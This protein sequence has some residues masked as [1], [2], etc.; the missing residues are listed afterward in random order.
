[1]Y[2]WSAAS[3]GEVRCQTSSV[4]AI[5]EASGLNSCFVNASLSVVSTSA[6]LELSQALL[7]PDN[8]LHD[9]LSWTGTCDS[10][11]HCV[12]LPSR[13]ILDLPYSMPTKSVLRRRAFTTRNQL[14]PTSAIAHNPHSFKQRLTHHADIIPIQQ[15]LR[16]LCLPAREITVLKSQHASL[17]LCLTKPPVR[18]LEVLGV[19]WG[20]GR[21]GKNIQFSNVLKHH[22]DVIIE[23][24][25]RP[26]EF[27]VA[28]HD[29]PDAR[30]DAFVD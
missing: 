2:I 11:S 1:L 9:H 29:H 12:L 19:R 8:R 22:V 10:R 30:A 15:N 17:M 20:S 24:E 16:Q 14:H 7:W 6:C 18:R 26:G 13:I 27:L 23:A 5:R 21:L 3:E 4:I 25:E 28:F